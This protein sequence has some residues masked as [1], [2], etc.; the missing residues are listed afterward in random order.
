MTKS[1]SFSIY[2]LKKGFTPEKSLGDEHGLSSINGAS[3]IP[4]SAS[5]FV[6]NNPPTSPW[7]RDYFGIEQDLDQSLKS[8]LLFVRVKGRYFV[9]SFGHAYSKLDNSSYEP[10]FGLLVTLNSIDSNKLNS[11]DTVEPIN[12]RRKRTQIPNA[13]DITLFDFDKDSSILRNITGRVKEEH[14]NF[15]RN[16]SG[17]SSIK[18]SSS[19]SADKI[20]KL[21]RTLLEL[22]N[23]NTYEDAFPSLL[24]ITPI[25]DPNQIAKLDENLVIALK[26]KSENLY[27]TIPEIIDYH[28]VSSVRFKSRKKSETFDDLY[29]DRYYEYLEHIE[30]NLNEVELEDI[31]KQMISLVDADEETERSSYQLYKCLVFD[32]KIQDEGGAFHLNE[33]HWYKVSDDYLKK[34]TDYLDRHCKKKTKLPHYNHK[35]ESAY[36]KSVPLK[37]SKFICLDRKNIAPFGQMEPC[38]L[39]TVDSNEAL[40][41]HVKHFRD[42]AGISH[43]LYQGQNS[44]RAI[45]SIDKCLQKLRRLL[46]SQ[47]QKLP[48]KKSDRFKVCFAIIT[49]KDIT[50]KSENLP[51]FSKISLMQALENLENMGL[52]AWYE[53]IKNKK[54]KKKR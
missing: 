9:L 53:Y 21:L 32:T 52:E 8:A 1:H 22:Y 7:W 13:S 4:K 27:L 24:N 16:P 42:S 51:I 39:Y 47:P 23:Q 37:K 29:L 25:K 10:N 3:S 46:K 20:S 2:L 36:N 19:V 33:G 45:R 18:I 41:I 26:E 30:K 35:D 15:F 38:D 34:L 12:G 48:L 5:L 54:P 49:H 28:Q 40:F 43:L 50:K 31:Q 17:A 14:K 6:G 11:T 44:A